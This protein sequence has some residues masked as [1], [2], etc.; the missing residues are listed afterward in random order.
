MSEE[1][2]AACAHK[3]IID[4]RIQ[5]GAGLITAEWWECQDCGTKFAP[6]EHIANRIQVFHDQCDEAQYT[7]TGEAWDILMWIKDHCAHHYK[8]PNWRLRS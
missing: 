3:H 4:C 8:E 2:G 6:V 7:D 5:K 1:H